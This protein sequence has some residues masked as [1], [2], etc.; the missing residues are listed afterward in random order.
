M[1]EVD[2]IDALELP[3][4]SRV[5]LAEKILES[6]DDYADPDLQAAWDNEVERRVKGIE[7]GAE[8]GISAAQV[9]KDA[10]C[11]LNE[12]RGLSSTRRK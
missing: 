2:D 9:M 4:R 12:T 6:M 1:V 10:R 11:A 3:S 7:S 5:R 8:K